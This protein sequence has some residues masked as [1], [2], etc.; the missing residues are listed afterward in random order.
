VIHQHPLGFLLGLEGVALL[1]AFAGE[2]DDAFMRARLDEVRA[3][4]ERDWGDGVDLPPI[5]PAEAYD[6]WA[7]GYDD[8]DNDLVAV[9]QR[10]VWGLLDALPPGVALDAACG[11]G[12]HA[13]H[14]AELGH[15][16]IGVDTSGGML[17][18][19]RAKVP[20][21]ELHL[22]DLHAL[23]LDEDSVDLVVCGLALMHVP[24]LEPVF[25]EFARV[26][27]PGGNLVVSDWRGIVGEIRMPLVKAGADGRLGYVPSWC[28]RTSEYIAAALPLGFEVR[29]CE[30]PLRPSPA[31]AHGEAPP[32]YDPGEAPSIWD[33]MPWIPAAA[34]A[35]FAG[36]A[37]A[38]VWQF[39]LRRA[40]GD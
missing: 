39:Q 6:G 3:L 26:L 23:P 29:H 28:R 9:E 5:A 7:A 36:S 27:R 37:I 1:R 10:A 33:L 15:R 16:V 8:G 17:A 2:H 35:A 38:V 24:R 4:L 18:L 14:L 21:A 30:E 40:V 11:T 34:N 25:D 13:A 19:A 12:R 22:A 20:S 32:P 31:V